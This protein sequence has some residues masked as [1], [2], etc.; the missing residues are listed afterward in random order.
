MKTVIGLGISIIVVASGVAV[1]ELVKGWMAS[2]N[3][4]RNNVATTFG[5]PIATDSLGQPRMAGV[6]IYG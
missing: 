6:T 2:P 4:P 3:N 5:M 1:Y